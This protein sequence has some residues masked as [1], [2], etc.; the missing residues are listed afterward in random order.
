[1]P[2]TRDEIFIRLSNSYTQEGLG[3]LRQYNNHVGNKYRIDINVLNKKFPL[4]EFRILKILIHF[5][6]GYCCEA[7]RFTYFD[8]KKEA[9]LF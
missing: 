7:H 3:R 8:R 6:K 1:M 9:K 2:F 4:V 5:L